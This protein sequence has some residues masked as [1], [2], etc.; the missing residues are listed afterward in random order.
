MPEPDIASPPATPGAVTSLLIAHR[1][2]DPE[3]YAQL[4]P[5]LYDHLRQVAHAQLRREARVRQGSHTLSTTALVHEAWFKLAEPGKLELQDRG[6]FFG[7]AARA[8]RQV[9]VDHARKVGA[10]KRGHGAAAVELDAAS[11]AV[12]ERADV[13]IALD[14][15][16]ERLAAM[17]PRLAR[18]VELRFFGGL[19]EEEVGEVLG[20][21]ERTVRRDWVKARGW[22]HAEIATSLA[23]V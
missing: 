22:L 11:L 4:F 14:E 8:M 20:V 6:H 18:V 9:L 10:A 16:L 19:T 3:A 15:A 17:S 13:L 12:E 7:A 21:T 5:L 1:G 23:T 2:G